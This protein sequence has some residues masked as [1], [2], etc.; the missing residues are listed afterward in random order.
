MKF[1]KYSG[2]GNDFIIL[3]EPSMVPTGEV[4]S[5]MCDRNFGIGADGVLILTHP[6]NADG[7]MRIFN[8][9]GGEAEMCANG[10]RCLVTYLDSKTHQSKNQYTIQT[11]NGLYPV[12]RFGDT[13]AIEMSE[14]KDQNLIDVSGFQGFL[15]SFY[16][17]TGVP[18][19][20]FLTNSINSIV[21]KSVGALYRYDPLFPRGTNVNFVE[22]IDPNHQKA[23]VRTYERGVEDETFSCGTG[24]TASA[25]ALSSWFGWKDVIR[26]ESKGGEH[27]VNVS[28]KVYY[29]GKVVFCFSGDYPL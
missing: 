9:D 24:M 27:Q 11:M 6:E 22:I 19:L 16:I 1:S 15:K 3:D 7:R 29:S 14:I 10:L 5:R 17:N 12:K 26:L 8:A 13:F 28:D 23:Y 4:L 2:N 20:V 21:I 25:L 18:H